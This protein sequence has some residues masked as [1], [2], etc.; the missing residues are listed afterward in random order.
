MN[1]FGSDID[2]NSSCRFFP[3]PKQGDR[4]LD[5]GGGTGFM[6]LA[7]Q[8][9]GFDVVLLEPTK[10]GVEAAKKKESSRSSA[11]VYRM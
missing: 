8:K 3:K 10:S 6:S 4:V 2:V 1:R 7:V 9:A 5:L 11:E